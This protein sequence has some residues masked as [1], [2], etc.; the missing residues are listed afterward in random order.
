MEEYV[1]IQT[2]FKRDM[3][4]PRNPIIEGDYSLPELAYLAGN[5][6]R[7]TE[8][9]DGT[10]IRV[11]FVDGQVV[12]G[13]RTEA[14]QIPATLVAVLNAKFLPLLD[15]LREV[16]DGDAV[17]YGEGYGA[18]I[19]KGGGNYRSD[20]SFV[21]FDVKVGEWW[22]QHEDVLDVADKL[23]L[24]TVPVLTCGTLHDAVAMAK[25][26]FLST[27]GNFEAEGIVARPT[28]EL[29]ARSGHRIIAK[30]KCR[31]FV[32]PA[33]LAQTKWEKERGW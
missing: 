13:G 25:S 24:E 14:A 5:Q 9:V 32:K 4:K 1:K 16:F 3:T 6:W 19:Q 18:K 7:F 15:K 8:K 2:I 27:W 17:L 22:L 30:I 26:G 11:G 33:D 12:Y 29:R 10:N 21:L 20:Q 23:E 28:T 31:D